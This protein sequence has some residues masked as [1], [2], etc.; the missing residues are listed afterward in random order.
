MSGAICGAGTDD[1]Y[2]RKFYR[3]KAVTLNSKGALHLI[4]DQEWYE[5]EVIL[6][7]TKGESNYAFRKRAEKH[8]HWKPLSFREF[9]KRRMKSINDQLENKIKRTLDRD[10]N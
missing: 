7:Q 2:I 1:F 3:R 4:M 10:N 9:M 5:P 8:L 6:K